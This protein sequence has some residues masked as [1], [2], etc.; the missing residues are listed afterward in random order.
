MLAVDCVDREILAG[1]TVDKRD[2]YFPGVDGLTVELMVDLD[3]IN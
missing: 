3:L 2:E 1:Q